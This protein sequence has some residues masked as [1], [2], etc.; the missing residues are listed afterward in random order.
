M[1]SQ[2]N[3]YDQGFYEINDPSNLM[4]SVHFFGDTHFSGTGATVTQTSQISSYNNEYLLEDTSPSVAFSN[5]LL[6]KKIIIKFLFFIKQDYLI[7]FSLTRIRLFSD[8]PS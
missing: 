2:G 6:N 4:N 3:V 7:F 8:D 1:A 5:A